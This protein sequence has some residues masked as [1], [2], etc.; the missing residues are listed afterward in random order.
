MVE[1][2]FDPITIYNGESLL[3]P[4]DNGH[5]NQIITKD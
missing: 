1:V 2:G 4:R 5:N 3:S